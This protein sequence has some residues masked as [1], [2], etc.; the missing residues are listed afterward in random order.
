ML[1]TERTFE[2]GKING[3]GMLQDLSSICPSGHEDSKVQELIL[4][5]SNWNESLIDE[6][7]NDIMLD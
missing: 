1:G 2:L 4:D 6:Q 7:F 5:N 3:L